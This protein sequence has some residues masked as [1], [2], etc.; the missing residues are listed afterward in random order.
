M[1]C[2][3]E[4]AYSVPFHRRILFDS[5]ANE[6]IRPYNHQW[7]VSVKHGK[8]KGSK[9]NMKVAGNSTQGA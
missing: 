3:A 7:W 5:G 9:V 6:I 2:A 8:R 4:E 1:Q